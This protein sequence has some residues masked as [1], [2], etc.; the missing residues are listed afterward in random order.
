[1]QTQNKSR[2]TSA[3]KRFLFAEADADTEGFLAESLS[4]RAK[5]SRKKKNREK[6]SK[7]SIASQRDII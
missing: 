7:V 6:V 5:L 4:H 3:G 1:M 2:K